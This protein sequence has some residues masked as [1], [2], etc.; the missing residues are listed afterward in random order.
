MTPPT[1]GLRGHLLIAD[2]EASVLETLTSV[3]HA[4]GFTNTCV[5]NGDEVLAQLRQHEFDAFISDLHMPGND[6]LSLIEN[7]AAQAVGLPILLLTGKPT[8]ATA[9]G[10]VRLPV[11]AYLT[12]PPDFNEL[13]QLLDKAIAD[14]RALRTMQAG[15]RRLHNWEEELERILLQHR[16]PT[17]LPG[18]QMGNYLRLTLRHVILVLFDLENAIRQLE[19]QSG[20]PQS[21]QNHDRDAA[22]RRAVEVLRRT[23]QSFKSRELAELRRELEQLL[24]R[25]SAPDPEGDPVAPVAG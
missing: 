14:Y 7:V 3:L 8:L 9:A 13:T 20:V 18:G 1:P 6:G 21:L 5:S 25:D 2:D 22:L 24:S 11:I 17:S 4:A 15:R 12:K 10:S 23:K 16:V 19:Q